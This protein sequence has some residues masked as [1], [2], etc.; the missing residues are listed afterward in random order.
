MQGTVTPDG[1]LFSIHGPYV[2]ST[3]DSG[4]L[5]QSGLIDRLREVLFSFSKKFIFNFK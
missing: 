3:N 2:G 1:M 4:M 5:T